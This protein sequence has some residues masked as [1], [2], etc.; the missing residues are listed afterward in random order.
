MTVSD[1]LGELKEI[2]VSTPWLPCIIERHNNNN[3]NNN[4][5]NNNNNN[6]NNNNKN[7]ETTTWELVK[8]LLT[9]LHLQSS[10]KGI[11]VSME[12]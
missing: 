4:D 2:W 11:L 6:N 8:Q 5:D 9:D 1:L 12:S 10:I 3:N 7:K